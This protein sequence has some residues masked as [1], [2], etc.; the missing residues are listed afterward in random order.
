[1]LERSLEFFRPHHLE[2]RKRIIRIFLTIIA[3]TAACYAFAEKIAAFFIAP[4]LQAS[5]FVHK[6]VYTNLP[7]AFISYLKLSLIV[8]LVV[9]FPIILYQI[10][11]FISPGLKSN[12]K[13]AAIL[14]VFW[15]SLLFTSGAAFAYFIVIP[16]MLLYFMSYAN[17]NLEPLPQFGTYLT[18]MART[19]MAFGLAFQIPFLMVMAGKTGLVNSTSFVK[20]RF[21]F[22]CG[23]VVIAFLLAAGDLMAT[24][25]L[26][27]PLFLLYEAG[28][29]LSSL[30]GKKAGSD[31]E[32]RPQ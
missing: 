32:I 16:R 1:M 20:K 27:G 12:E 29:F 10:W 28:I 8:G 11:I 26:S 3:A 19:V 15:A 5:P 17:P 18:F 6:L 14:I 7:E 21:Y 13:K 24:A 31:L 22:Y 25:L 2:L 30:F 9:S 23:I 4:L